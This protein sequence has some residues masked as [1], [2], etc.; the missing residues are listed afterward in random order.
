[1]AEVKC[2]RC[3]RSVRRGEPF[4]FILGGGVAHAGE[5]PSLH[6]AD[7]GECYEEPIPDLGLRL[8]PG[9]PEAS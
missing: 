4:T 8:R 9:P 1:M 3:G 7:D 2:Q 5:C 6:V